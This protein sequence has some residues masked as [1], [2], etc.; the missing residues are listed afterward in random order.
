MKQ[1]IKKKYKETEK[2]TYLQE[3]EKRKMIGILMNSIPVRKPKSKT[4]VDSEKVE[5]V[6]DSD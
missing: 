6:Q 4:E 1:N 3:N 2:E 5:K